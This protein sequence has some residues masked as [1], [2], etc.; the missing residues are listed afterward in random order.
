MLS[1]VHGSFFEMGNRILWKRLHIGF[2]FYTPVAGAAAN[3]HV[4]VTTFCLLITLGTQ[5][6]EYL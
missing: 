5:A 2:S 4:R 6:L 3:D 1:V